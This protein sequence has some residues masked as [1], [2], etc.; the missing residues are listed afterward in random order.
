[1][2]LQGCLGQIKHSV[3]VGSYDHDWICPLSQNIPVGRKRKKLLEHRR[4]AGLPRPS[5]PSPIV[6]ALQSDL[7]RLF[8]LRD[9]GGRLP[10]SA[11]RK[12]SFLWS[13]D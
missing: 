12:N 11:K 5:A 9:T 4:G 7:S 3:D 2:C 8:L 6:S 1:M 13:P 10:E